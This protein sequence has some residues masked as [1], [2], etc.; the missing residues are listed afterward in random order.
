M[1]SHP[2]FYFTPYQ[3]D[4]QAALEVLR[5]QE[6]KAGR[7]YPVT[8]MVKFN[9]PPDDAS[10]T[11][12]ARHSSIAEAL[13]ASGDKLTGSILDITRITDEPDFLAACPLPPNKLIELFGTTEPTRDR[14]ETLF[15]W[16]S[17]LDKS[18][19]NAL[20]EFL[21]DIER[22]QAHY[23]VVYDKSEPREIFFLGYSIG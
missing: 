15:T 21:D 7:Y 1:G 11:P 14:I 22:G 19:Q 16:D 4:V 5:E 9:F 23:I 2:Y 18:T 13:D 8:A 3:K 12:G 6:F 20:V 17:R 10:R